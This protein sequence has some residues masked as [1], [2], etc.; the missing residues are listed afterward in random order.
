MKKKKL[1][2]PFLM[3]LAGVISSIAMYRF[4][5]TTA[6]MLP[7]LVVVLLVFYVAGIL[8]QKNVVSFMDEITEKEE[9]IRREAE[10]RE[11]AERAA[12]EEALMEDSGEE[13]G[14]ESPDMT[15]VQT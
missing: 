4:H 15:T 3:L 12:A 7:V 5:Y 9:A 1:F 8:I 13:N 10:E 6:E 2:A 14:Q 11:A